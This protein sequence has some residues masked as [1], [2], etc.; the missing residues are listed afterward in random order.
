MRHRF[1]LLGNPEQRCLYGGEG[2]KDCSC[3]QVKNDNPRSDN[4]KESDRWPIAHDPLS[5]FD[6]SFGLCLAT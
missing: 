1:Y 5:S 4:P 3:L 6:P 2:A